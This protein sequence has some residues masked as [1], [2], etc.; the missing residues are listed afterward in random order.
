MFDLHFMWAYFQ[1]VLES[2][3]MTEQ[4]NRWTKQALQVARA[5]EDLKRYGK[6]SEARYLLLRGHDAIDGSEMPVT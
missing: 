6:T 1:E 3:K 5:T 4:I 2:R